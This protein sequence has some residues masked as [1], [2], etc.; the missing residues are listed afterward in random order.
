MEAGLPE[1]SVQGFV[2]R[3]LAGDTT[4]LTAVTLS[5]LAAA[6][7]ALKQVTAKSFE[8]VWVANAV[9]GAITAIC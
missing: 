4:D 7:D 6:D 5:I 2:T 3:F 8:F 1:S 9:I